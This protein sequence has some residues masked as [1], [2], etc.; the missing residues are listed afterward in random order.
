MAIHGLHDV[1][2]VTLISI[3]VPSSGVRPTGDYFFEG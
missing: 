1:H 3:R 2:C